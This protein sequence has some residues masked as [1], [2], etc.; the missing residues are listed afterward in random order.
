MDTE[1]TSGTDDHVKNESLK[2]QMYKLVSH[3]SYDHFQYLGAYFFIQLFTKYLLNIYY[4]P[5]TIRGWIKV[6]LE[7]ERSCARMG[8]GDQ[9][10]QHASIRSSMEVSK[11]FQEVPE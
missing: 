7:H 9:C 3:D 1:E 8:K 5:E 10:S 11:L 6:F 4:V 2:E